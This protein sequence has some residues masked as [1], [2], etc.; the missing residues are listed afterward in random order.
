VKELAMSSELRAAHASR[1]EGGGPNAE[2]LERACSLVSD[3]T[4]GVSAVKI[5]RVMLDAE[6]ERVVRAIAD[7]PGLRL[8]LKA[9]PSGHEADLVIEQ[10]IA[11][12]HHQPPSRAAC[13]GLL[14]HLLPRFWSKPSNPRTTSRAD[15][16]ASAMRDRR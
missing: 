7:R 14:A 1:A 15:A 16:T 5:E 2:T 9:R 3:T 11:P 6:L 8:V 4:N 10:A 12:L 13:P